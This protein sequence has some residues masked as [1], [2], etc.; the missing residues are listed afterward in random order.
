MIHINTSLELQNK[1][2]IGAYILTILSALQILN[3]KYNT[4]ELKIPNKFKYKYI[5]QTLWLNSFVYINT[6]ILKPKVFISPSFIMPYLTRKKTKYITVIHDLCSI[7][8][9]EMKN[10]SQF[11]FNLSIKIAIK[12]ADII[13]TVSETV[14]QELIKKFDIPPERIKVVYNSIAEHFINDR[15]NLEI[16]TKYNI[17][18]NNYILSVATLNK[19]KNIPELIKAFESISNKYPDMKLVL[20]GGMGNENRAKLT[21]HPNIIFTGYIPD[22]NIPTL[23]K[24]ALLYVFPS[25][26]E[27]FGT[28]IIE[29]QYSGCLLLCSDIPVFREIAGNGAEFCKTNS[30]SITKKIEYLIKNPNRR[31]ELITLGY[32]NVKRFTKKNISKQLENII[33]TIA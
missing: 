26:Y 18:K 30:H 17:Q 21:K 13:V 2:G 5:W 16:L 14:R 22:E 28:P 24:N 32:E 33:T 12:K 9:N 31:E 19:R 25:L 7:R 11:I 20:V 3:Q 1:T 8:P 10:Y 15:N 27:G 4:I 6:L 23:Y 29:A